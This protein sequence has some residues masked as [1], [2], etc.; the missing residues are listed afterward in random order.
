MPGTPFASTPNMPS[1]ATFPSLKNRTVLVTGGATGIGASFVEHFAAQGAHLGF[2]DLDQH[3][4]AAL[5]AQLQSQGVTAHFV[6]ADITDTPATVAAIAAIRAHC[7]LITVLVNNAA[8]D[9]RHSVTQTT[10][11]SWDAGVAVNLKHQ[12]FCAQAVV[13]DM[14]AAGGGSIINLGSISWMLKMGGLPVY[15]ICKAAVQGLTKSL[16]RD[17]G[18]YNIRVNSLVAGAVLTDKQLKLWLDAERIAEINRNQCLHRSIYPG[19]VARMA[20]FLAADDSAMCT[21][22]DFVVD[23]GW[24]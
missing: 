8:N 6:C 22:Q 3:A 7:G 2:I 4:G 17:L 1:Y 10:P 11:A 18:D 14:Q 23:G 16:A 9:A 13:P 20:L 24:A 15:T 21:A 19:D 5:A 12:F